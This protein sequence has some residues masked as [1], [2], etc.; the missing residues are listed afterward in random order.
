MGYAL[1]KIRQSKKTA[2]ISKKEQLKAEFTA[3]NAILKRKFLPVGALKYYQELYGEDYEQRRCYIL[4]NEKNG[5]IRFTDSIE[6]LLEQES[7]HNDLYLHPC[8]FFNNYPKLATMKRLYAFVVDLDG[9]S[10]YDL[11]Q[12]VQ[13]ITAKGYNLKPTY[14]VNS[15]NGVHLV[16][17]LEKPIET[18]N[19]TKPH[20]KAL[21]K[22]LKAAYEG[23]STSY[24]VDKQTSIMQS[25]RVVGSRTK[26]GQR[27]T[28]FC[29]GQKWTVDALATA[30]RL[31]ILPT[32]NTSD[33]GPAKGNKGNKGNNDKVVYMPN[34]HA[35][36]Y[37]HTLERIRSEVT[38]GHRYTAMFA[39]AIVGYKAKCKINKEQVRNDLYE[40]IDFWNSQQC[41]RKMRYEEISKAC[42]GYSQKF[43]MVRHEVL[44]NWLG[45]K[46]G[47]N[48]RNGKKQKEHLKEARATR[49][50]KM[51]TERRSMMNRYLEQHPQATLNELVEVLGWSKHTVIKYRKLIKGN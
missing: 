25:Y 34:A 4:A 39:L 12:L 29:V 46:F 49:S 11:R 18:Y 36:F 8:S 6:T 14:I 47:T 31:P 16:Y 2:Y 41:K 26:L 5:R 40:L 19:K 20:L 44:E 45:F 22:A 38:E 17:I 43:L 37:T 15:G 7:E 23:N 9:V 28:A 50:K 51:E 10:S 42:K 30:L 27:A 3:K 21:L 32:S 33:P 35:G 1:K 13:K 48:K 24:K